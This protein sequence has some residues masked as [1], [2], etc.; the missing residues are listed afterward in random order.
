[1]AASVVGDRDSPAAAEAVDRGVDREAGGRDREGAPG[2]PVVLARAGADPAG[3]PRGVDAGARVV[4]WI[5]PHRNQRL[6]RWPLEVW[7]CLRC[8]AIFE[9]ADS[10]VP[11]FTKA[12]HAPR[13]LPAGPH[14]LL[15]WK[16]HVE[17]SRSLR[18]GRA[19][20][21]REGNLPAIAPG[22]D[23]W[24]C[25][26]CG[27]AGPVVGW[28]DAKTGKARWEPSWTRVCLTCRRRRSGGRLRCARCRTLPRRVR[29]AKE[30]A[31]RAR[32]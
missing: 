26:W 11:G 25:P 20:V 23:G 2:V 17:P 18:A 12:V 5:V 14:D 8:K 13:G 3:E 24:T 22:A 16:R 9:A 32:G 1:M 31:G 27:R 10:G 28:R 30:F 15:V 29:D 4:S 6:R 7:K 21:L 19:R